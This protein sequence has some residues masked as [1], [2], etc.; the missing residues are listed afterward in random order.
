MYVDQLCKELLGFSYLYERV[1]PSQ[2]SKSE[3]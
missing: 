2:L 3:A 1:F